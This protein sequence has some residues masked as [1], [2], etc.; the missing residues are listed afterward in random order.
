MY[1]MQQRPH[2]TKYVLKIYCVVCYVNLELHRYIDQLWRRVHINN[3][4]VVGNWNYFEE[5]ISKLG[6][7]FNTLGIIHIQFRSRVRVIKPLCYCCYC[8][9]C[10][11]VNKYKESDNVSYNISNC[12]AEKIELVLNTPNVQELRKFKTNHTQLRTFDVNIIYTVG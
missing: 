6:F 2:F 9:Y 7:Q 8:F 10:L 4:V 1:S 5:L 3:F 12:F 11:I